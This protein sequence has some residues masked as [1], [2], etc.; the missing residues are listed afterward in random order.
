MRI[1]NLIQSLGLGVYTEKLSGKELLKRVE[2]FR[3]HL[4]DELTITLLESMG[5]GVEVHQM[6]ND[7]ILQSIDK[8]KLFQQEIIGT[9]T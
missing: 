1:I 2:E 5:M 9:A 4:G 3:E 7:L 8:L 6:E